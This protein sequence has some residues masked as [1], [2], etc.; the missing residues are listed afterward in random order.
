MPPRCPVARW[1]GPLAGW[2]ALAAATAAS[3]QTGSPSVYLPGSTP[4]GYQASELRTQWPAEQWPVQ[5]AAH[6]EAAPTAGA[7]AIQPGRQ[8]AATGRALSAETGA[9]LP[10]PKPAGTADGGLPLPRRDA[11]QGSRSS[12]PGGL[13]SLVTVGGSLAVVLGLFLLV[14]WGLR[15]AVPRSA[16]ALPAE[17]FEM[18]GRA[19][20]AGR[21]QVHLLRCGRKLLLVSISPAGAET[22]T[23][24]TEPEEVDRLAGLCQQTRSG[25]ATAT[26][27]QVFQQLSGHYDADHG[28]G[29]A[30]S[31]S[32]WE[33]QHA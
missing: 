4:Q 32:G 9:P 31:R 33:E 13:G 30:P 6:Y 17:V 14:A 19:P 20:L 3:A 15:R 18:L 5:P 1:I 29:F 26:F 27:R 28:G 25:S 11:S 16:T 7:P 10:L 21:Q 22:L 8:A 23:E 12:G 2:I 24:I